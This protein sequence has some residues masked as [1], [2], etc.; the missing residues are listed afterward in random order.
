MKKLIALLLMTVLALSLVACGGNDT[1]SNSTSAPPAS[2]NAPAQT[3]PSSTPEAAPSNNVDVSTIEGFLSQFGLT[4][5]D[6]KPEGAGEGSHTTERE[7]K[8]GRVSWMAEDATAEV[9]DEWIQAI[10]EKTKALATDG[11]LYA[12]SYFEDEFSFTSITDAGTG[13]IGW[14]YYYSDSEVDI[15]CE[16]LDGGFFDFNININ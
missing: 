2:T 6:V 15:T 12:D 9:K 1:P 4:E 11:K 10:V 13:R 14:L 5:A 16:V 8:R 3:T 7:G